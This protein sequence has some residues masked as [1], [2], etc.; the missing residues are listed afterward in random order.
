MVGMA[1]Y[2]SSGLMGRPSLG[3]AEKGRLALD[4]LP[5]AFEGHHAELAHWVESR[6]VVDEGVTA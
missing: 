1:D 5:R 6:V 3:T 2:T 4:G